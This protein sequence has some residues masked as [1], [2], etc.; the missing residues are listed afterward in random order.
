MTQDGIKANGENNL[1]NEE[2]QD[3]GVFDDSLPQIPP[4]V[5][6][7][8]CI[9]CGHTSEAN[10]E[11]R[12]KK[13]TFIF[14]IAEGPYAGTDLPRYYNVPDNGRYNRN[15]AYF[16]DWFVANGGKPPKR[17]DRLSSTVFRYKR[18]DITVRDAQDKSNRV[19]YS[20]VGQINKLLSSYDPT[21]KERIIYNKEKEEPTLSTQTS[22]YPPY[23]IPNT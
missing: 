1:G 19:T 17:G 8:V 9:S 23:P 3:D 5:Y 10:P 18:F 22:T 14:K 4:G 2:S 12:H 6:K 13:R 16:K 11:W 20:V 15:H 21:T 7:A